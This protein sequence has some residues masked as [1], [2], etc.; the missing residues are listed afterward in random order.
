MALTGNPHATLA[1]DLIIGIV[2]VMAVRSLARSVCSRPRR[3][4]DSR[5]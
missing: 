1:D 4:S 2:L 3:N 5:S